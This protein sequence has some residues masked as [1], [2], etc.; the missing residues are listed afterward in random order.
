MNITVKCNY[1]D[2]EIEGRPIRVELKKKNRFQI[3]RR[4]GM[5]R[6]YSN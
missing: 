4:L 3:I 6:R 1:I 2:A 5:R